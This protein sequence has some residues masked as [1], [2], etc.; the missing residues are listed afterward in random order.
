MLFATMQQKDS[1]PSISAVNYQIK[2]KKTKKYA[3]KKMGWTTCSAVNTQ[4]TAQFL[5]WSM[6]ESSP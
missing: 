1:F 6:F 5:Y 3:K 4:L 2:A